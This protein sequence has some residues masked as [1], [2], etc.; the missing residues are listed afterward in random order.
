MDWSPSEMDRLY[1][2][3]QQHFHDL[4]SAVTSANRLHGSSQPE[5]T[6]MELISREDFERLLNNPDEPEVANRWVRRLI[7]G[8]EREFPNLQVA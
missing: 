2:L 3:Y 1:E 7:R 4:R 5:E 8:H 6:W